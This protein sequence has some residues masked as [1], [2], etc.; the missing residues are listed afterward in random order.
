[1]W[2][3]HLLSYK[4]YWIMS[5]QR[6]FLQYSLYNGIYN[7]NNFDNQNKLKMRLKVLKLYW[8]SPITE[9]QTSQIPFLITKSISTFSCPDHG[10]N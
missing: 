6:N 10:I 4:Q 9:I 8:H 1:M 2:H 5:D 7:K 3:T